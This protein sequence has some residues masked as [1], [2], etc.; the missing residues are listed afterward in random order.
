MSVFMQSA[1]ITFSQSWE[2]KQQESLG[3]WYLL[4]GVY[5]ARLKSLLSRNY[6]MA[7]LKKNL[8][9][10]F[11]IHENPPSRE[12]PQK[13]GLMDAVIPMWHMPFHE[14]ILIYTSKKV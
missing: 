1:N 8:T 4:P 2:E 10:M 7:L 6:K 12:D 14:E 9:G 11:L 3:K 5:T 13:P